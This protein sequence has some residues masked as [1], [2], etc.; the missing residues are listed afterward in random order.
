VLICGI[1]GM[2]VA[3]KRASSIK[4][5]ASDAEAPSSK[6]RLLELATR[7]ASLSNLVAVTLPDN[8]VEEI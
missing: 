4:P 5:R 1:I 6:H 7:D 3:P 8:V 2:E